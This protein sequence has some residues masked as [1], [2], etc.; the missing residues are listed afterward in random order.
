MFRWFS[1]FTVGGGGGGGAAV[2][3]V[4]GENLKWLVRS[5]KIA[6]YVV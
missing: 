2:V 6:F 1:F 3:V 4:G 5:Y